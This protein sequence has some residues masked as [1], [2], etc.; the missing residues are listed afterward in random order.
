MASGVGGFRVSVCK[1]LLATCHVM[2]KN[3][4]ILSLPRDWDVGS[5]MFFAR[6]LML[7]FQ[8]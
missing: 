6:F 4:R 7:S 2:G 1:G 5:E 3:I 8:G